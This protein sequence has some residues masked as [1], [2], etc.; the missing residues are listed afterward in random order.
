VVGPLDNG[1]AG[2]EYTFPD[3]VITALTMTVTWVSSCTA[4]VG[5]AEIQVFGSPSSS[6]SG[7]SGSSC[8]EGSASCDRSW[9][10][11]I[12]NTWSPAVPPKG[13]ILLHDGHAK[14]DLCTIEA[15]SVVPVAE[16]LADEGYFVYGLE[17]PP[18]PHGPDSNF[19]G[20]SFS[21]LDCLKEKGLPIYMIGLSGGGWTTTMVTTM[22]PEIKRGYSVAGDHPTLCYQ[23][24]WENQNPPIEYTEAYQIAGDRLLH[25]YNWND[26]CCFAHIEGDIG[27]KYVT[28]YDNKLHSISDWALDYIL[29]DI[30][31]L[32]AD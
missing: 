23:Y 10:G 20:P 3:K 19:F 25:I 28:D 15:N 22:R 27:T 31:G 2:A 5:L 13:F 12:V 24:D 29:S 11:G 18:E 21:L 9:T 16:R 32:E 17:M 14:F 1:G 6:S 4:D 30:A 26:P 7:D 8:W